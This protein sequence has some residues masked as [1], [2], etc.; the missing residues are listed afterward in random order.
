MIEIATAINSLLLQ[1]RTSDRVV[2]V[3]VSELQSLFESSVALFNDLLGEA[4]EKRLI[5]KREAAELLTSARSSIDSEKS[6]IQKLILLHA[7]IRKAYKPLRDAI[8]RRPAANA[9]ETIIQA[10]TKIKLRALMLFEHVKAIATEE[11]RKKDFAFSSP[12]ARLLLAGKEGAAPSRRDTIRAMERAEKLFPALRCEHTPGDGRQT[13]R[14][15]I[16][17]DDLNYGEI[18]KEDRKR[19]GWQRFKMTEVLP[20]MS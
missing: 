14:F 2:E 13:M 11:N 6:P 20:F 4:R 17:I 12:D 16:R 1:A 3:P 18:I 8:E 19:D 15:L 5:G 7:Y 10:A 9:A